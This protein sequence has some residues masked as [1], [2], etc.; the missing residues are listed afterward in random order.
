MDL[1]DSFWDKL[2]DSFVQKD[3]RDLFE[4]NKVISN[5]FLHVA[6][7]LCSTNKKSIYIKKMLSKC[8]RASEHVLV[9]LTLHCLLPSQAVALF[10][11]GWLVSNNEYLYL[12]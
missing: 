6:V 11:F 7:C 4:L 10:L 3:I 2:S 12:Y 1:P 8:G 5:T 9:Q